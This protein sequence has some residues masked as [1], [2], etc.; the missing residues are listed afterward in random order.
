MDL[1]THPSMAANLCLLVQQVP[2]LWFC[3]HNKKEMPTARLI[4]R[5]RTQMQ[6]S[7]DRCWLGRE[8]VRGYLSL[9]ANP[10]NVYRPNLCSFKRLTLTFKKEVNTMLQPNSQALNSEQNTLDKLNQS[11]IN[12]CFA[13]ADLNA[14]LSKADLEILRTGGAK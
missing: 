3:S 6:K 8:S 12:V 4:H 11:F 5:L 2:A 9:S 13:Y 14:Y 7:Y 10:T 1:L